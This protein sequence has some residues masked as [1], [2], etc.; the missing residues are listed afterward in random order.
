MT[1]FDIIND[2]LFKKKGNLLEKEEAESEFQ[3]YMVQRWLSMY[4]NV[5]VKI[6]N[7]TIN[8]LGKHLENKSQ[9]YKLF[10]DTLPRSK[11]K[12]IRYIKKVSA[13]TQ[14]T[15]GVS[16]KVIAFIAENHQISP[17]EVKLYIE[18]Y[19]LDVSSIAKTLEGEKR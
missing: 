18:E 17:R 19:G 7:G 13:K 12:K 5:N 16:D 4:S 1:I 9:W 10:L 2:I 8:K 6:L 11:Y 14:N 3:P 15:T